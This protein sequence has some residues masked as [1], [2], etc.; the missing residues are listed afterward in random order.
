VSWLA[1]TRPGGGG[2]IPVKPGERRRHG[3]FIS[4]ARADGEAAARGLEARLKADAPDIQVWLDRYEAEGGVG[5]WNQIEQALD[6]AEFFLLVMTPAAAR[7]ENTRR[8]WR[9]ARQRGVC[10]YPVTDSGV[11]RI[12]FASL[13][14]WMAKAHCYDLA[15]E[16][17]K[18]LAHL[19]RGCVATRVPFM[20]PPVT[21]GFVPRP[22]QAS[23]LCD[24][25]LAARG[26]G[27]PSV[28]VLRGPGGFGKT[29]LAAAVCQDERL[30]EAFDDGILWVTLG[31]APNLLNELV[32]LYAALTGERPAFVDV[33]D[34][35]RELALRLENKNC[36]LVIDDVWHAGHVGPFQAG[37]GC[38]FL[39]TTRLLD[40]AAGSARIEIEQMTPDEAAQLLMRRAGVAAR[41]GLAVRPLVARLGEW[42]LAVTLAGSAMRQRIERGDSPVSALRAVER[43]LEKRGITAF[44][45]ED[46]IDRNEAVARTV[47]ASL[48][49]LD[50]ASQRRCAELAIFPEDAAVSI[51]TASALWQLDDLDS[52]D[53]ARRLDDLALIEFDMRLD[54][55]RMHDV[56]RGLLLARLPDTAAVHA[57]LLE[58]WGDP[59]ALPHLHAWRGCAYHLVRAG[60][61]AQLRALLLDPRWLDAKLAATDVASLASDFDHLPDDAVLALV[62]DA[63]RLSA[64]AVARHREQLRTQLLGRLLARPEPDIA[65]LRAQL[66][67]LAAP[68]LQ[69]LQPV[70][71][72]PGGMLLMTLVGHAGEVTALAADADFRRLLSAS[73]DGSVRVWD[74]GSGEL[75]Q[76]FDHK[77]LG[78]RAVAVSRDGRFA[79]SAGA[80]GMLHP[81]DVASGSRSTAPLGAGGRARTALALSA[82]GS[83]AVSASRDP[84]VVVWDVASGT[85]RHV[86]DGHDERV[87]AVGI[88]ADAT[89]AISASDDGTARVW[90][91]LTGQQERVLPHG[92]PINALS[93]SADG[94][95]AVTGSSD[96]LLKMWNLDDGICVRT[97]THEAGIESVALAATGW[98]AIS[99]SSDQAIW[100]WN[101]RDGSLLAQLDGHS[102]SVRAV[103]INDS[104]TRAATGSIDRSIKLWR[105]DNP[106]APAGGPAPW[107]S[108]LAVDFS[109]DGR[110]CVSGGGDGRVTIRDAQSGRVVRA[111]DAHAG[112]VRSVAMSQ[113]NT[114]VLSTG[115]DGRF[116]I[117]T[118]DDGQGV[119][120]PI[121]HGAP[122]DYCVFSG[123]ARYLT[124]ACADRFVYL[125]DVPSGVLLARYGSRSLF[126]HLITPSPRR[127]ASGPAEL[128]D[129]YLPGEQV[130][131]TVVARMTR[132]GEYALLSAAVRE[133]GSL[134]T[135]AQPGAGEN[136]TCV[137]VLHIATGE[138]RTIG[139]R[140]PDPIVALALDGGGRRLLC[141]RSDHS[142][143][144]WDL[145]HE[146]RV[147]T[148]A[149]HEQKVND[150]AFS[151]DGRFAF[152]CARDRT[153]RAWSLESGR[154]VATY[155]ADAALRALAISPLDGTVAAGDV[156]GRMH[157]LRLQEA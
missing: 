45:R 156:A 48:D 102:D 92:A 129:R 134:R 151:R 96:R 67:Q 31:Q 157:F 11:E 86:F 113:D 83:V 123:T 69:P 154:C 16:W 56:L 55:I 133:Q 101:L 4:Y 43:T 10:V 136:R 26:D 6:R 131:E 27:T 66:A 135:D 71:D 146:Q 51:A 150:V 37:A 115:V 35:S 44:D 62:R 108:L 60:R 34:A 22:R 57:R 5:W 33:E 84:Q 109:A 98:R 39:V 100:L 17:P 7:S 147:A 127:A 140:Q 41:D 14:G 78:V 53:L 107:G 50:P 149:G 80:D 12:D 155:T 42:P 9:S 121:R 97:L 32:K 47:A 58:V 30:V 117:W 137:L 1:A 118:I 24:A 141:A 76:V 8:E 138:I 148:L 85:V 110:F 64:P 59:Y 116:W 29:T 124:A 106:R 61:E 105:L 139:A 23:E 20:A 49:L 112:P 74:A 36:L 99:G 143:D 75:L 119:S 15:V 91:L 94:R 111:I 103:T 153:V 72:A 88:S 144:I 89:R 65:A 68:W 114:C 125:W 2:L 95:H 132:D 79:M 19:R 38:A 73:E 126:D 70:L 104:G 25:L 120:I 152:S 40:V 81:W 82:D 3:A 77:R 46:A 90:D 142:L 87:T 130:Y 28:T 122:V 63:V 52:E 21:T 128:R 54:V 93:M 13:P 18:L 145:R